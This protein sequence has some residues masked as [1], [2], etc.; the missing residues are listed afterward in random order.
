MTGCSRSQRVCAT[1]SACPA[2]LERVSGLR[3][4]LVQSSVWDAVFRR[5]GEFWTIAYGGQ[6]FRLRDLK[7]LRYIAALLTSPER[8][9]HVVELIGAA[10][11]LPADARSELG[12][13]DVAGGWPAELDPVLDDQARQEYGR[14]L[15]ELEEELERARGWADIERAARLQSE[16]DLLTEELSRAVGLRGRHRTFSSPEERA[17]ISVTKAIKTAIRLIE[18]QCSCARGA[19]R[20]LDPDRTLLLLRH[21][22][23]R[24]APLVA[25][26]RSA[27]A[28]VVSPNQAARNG[29][30]NDRSAGIHAHRLRT[31]ITAEGRQGLTPPT[32][33][34]S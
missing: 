12:E 9:V 24:C 27:V 25:L 17:R 10:T 1:S 6:M 4:R 22:G 20:S 2:S 19:L 18:K 34:G 33:G 31:S 32:Q 16:L 29:M 15:A 13:D 28:T 21:T 3:E 26:T 11:G 14:R 8:E 5:E 30:R 7:G 23:R